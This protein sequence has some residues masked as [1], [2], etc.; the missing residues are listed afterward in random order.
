MK[1]LSTLLSPLLEKGEGILISHSSLQARYYGS[2]CNLFTPFFYLISD[3]KEHL[4]P[5][6]FMAQKSKQT[7]FLNKRVSN[8]E[9]S[10][11]SSFSSGLPGSYLNKKEHWDSACL[12]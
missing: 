1:V 11:K 7:G 5:N 9:I 12:A 8:Q 6:L 10:G 2:G 3:T 4:L